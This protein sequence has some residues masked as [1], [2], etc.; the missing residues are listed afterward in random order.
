MFT[1]YTIQNRDIMKN[2]S[3]FKHRIFLQKNDMVEAVEIYENEN[4]KYYS[5]L[6]KIWETKSQQG[7]GDWRTLMRWDNYDEKTHVDIYGE[8]RNLVRQHSTTEHKSLKEVTELIKIF[9]R[10]LVAMNFSEM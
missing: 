7:Q 5:Y 10:N 2:V 8:N 3:I 6:Y 9:R 1:Y 4:L